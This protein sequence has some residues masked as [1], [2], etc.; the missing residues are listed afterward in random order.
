MKAQTREVKQLLNQWD[1]IVEKNG[2]LYCSNA[3]S[4]GKKHQQLL[5]PASLQD[6]LLKGV[7]DQCGRQGLER[8]EQLVRERCWWPG[9]HNDVKKYLSECELCVVAKGPYL[10]DKTPM[11]SI[12]ATK[13][14]EVLAMDFT[15]LEPA[16]DGREN[17]LV[18][19]DVFT[20]FTVAVPTRDQRASTAFKTL[21]REW[22][23]V[24]GVPKAKENSF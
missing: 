18:L 16:S 22:F 20:K 8:T 11:T 1:R 3:D 24:Y 21:V 5:L 9:L 15:Q 13:L 14:L 7:H 12:I 19:T 2:V 17:V 4:H 6:E 10:T 23:L